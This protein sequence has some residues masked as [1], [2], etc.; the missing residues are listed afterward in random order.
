M[1]IYL[2]VWPVVSFE[3]I[4]SAAIGYITYAMLLLAPVVLFHSATSGNTALAPG[5]LT[6][7]GGYSASLYSASCNL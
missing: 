3:S 2:K 7:R 4:V 6:L 5:Q 1:S